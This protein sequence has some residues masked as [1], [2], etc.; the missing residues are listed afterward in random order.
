MHSLTLQFFD[1]AELIRPAKCEIESA[2]K[3]FINHIETFFA[4]RCV[5]KYNAID[6]SSS[7]Q[8]SDTKLAKQAIAGDS[9]AFRALV[10]HYGPSIYGYA[11]RLTGNEADAEDIAQETFIRLHENLSKLDISDPLK[12]WLFRVC[13]NL[14][15]NH[16]KRK[17]LLL[18]S[19]LEHEDSEQPS[20]SESIESNEEPHSQKLDR[21]SEKQQVQAAVRALPQKYQVVI[22]LY[23][24]EGLSYEEIASMLSL[25][26]NTVRTHLKRAKSLLSS[27]LQHLLTS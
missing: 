19:Q 15:R 23:Y 18:F 17:K 27:S 6:M 8:F 25:P 7:E 12:P 22:S 16:A 20:M 5:R 2:K 10:E 14:C 26:I 1:F 9:E 11:R 21:Y 4:S 13:T 24:W 3:N